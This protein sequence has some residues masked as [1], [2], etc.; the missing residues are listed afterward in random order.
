MLKIGAYNVLFGRNSQAVD[1]MGIQ[2]KNQILEEEREPRKKALKSNRNDTKSMKPT[3]ISIQVGAPGSETQSVALSV[4]LARP[5]LSTSALIQD[6]VRNRTKSS[7]HL[8]LR[9][10][11][12]TKNTKYYPQVVKLQSS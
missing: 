12:F 2:C 1:R 4:T 11:Y 5:G 6:L 10:V 3:K 7:L 8:A 9:I